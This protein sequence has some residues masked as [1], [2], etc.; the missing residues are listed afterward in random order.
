MTLRVDVEWRK[1]STGTGGT[2][3]FDPRPNLTRPGITQKFVE[4]AIPLLDGNIIQLLNNTSRIIRLRGVLVLKRDPNFDNLDQKRQEF[5]DGL[6]NDVGQ[7]HIISNRGQANSKHIFY[8][9]VPTRITFDEQTNS[10]ILVYS[11]EIL[12]ADPAENEI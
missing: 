11:V 10:K 5:L 2:F 8:N 9:G 1:G 12:L 3:V 4:L 6:G 7:L